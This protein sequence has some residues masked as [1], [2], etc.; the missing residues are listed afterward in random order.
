MS[1]KSIKGTLEAESINMFYQML[2]ERDQVCV[3][4]RE[5]GAASKSINIRSKKLKLKELAIF[6]RQ[7]STML[8][9]GLTVIKCLDVLYQQTT[10]KYLK[11]VI[12]Q[13]YESVQKGEALSKAMSSQ[14]GVF[15]P[16]FL[17]MIAAGEVGGT[18]DEVMARMADQYEK[19]NKLNNKITQALIY[20]IILVFLTICVVVM[21]LVFIVP[22]FMDM[23]KEYGGTI[24]APT[25]ILLAMSG[26]MTNYWYIIIGVVVVIVFAWKAFLRSETGR[27]W[28]DKVKIKLPVIGK[29]LLV[30]I[31]SRFSRTFASLYSS[32]IPIVQSLDIVGGVLNNKFVEEKV[33]EVSGN[34][35]RGT[36]LSSAV[37]KISVFPTMLCSMLSIGEESGN[38]EDILKKTAAFYDEESDTAIQKLISLIEPVMIIILAVIVCF[39]IL[40]IILPIYTI[41]NSVDASV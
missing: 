1:G 13:V 26:A 11:S 32:G 31:S 21:M 30:I 20:P 41:Y 7:F 33:Q 25:R 38:L 24:P 9:S 4:V 28:W 14:D 10:G 15:P 5:A 2:S 19:E 16:L 17:S 35:S 3:S 29:L 8:S 34:V 12:L 40:S 18:L 23:F 37:R 27:L 36:S 39:V 6:S 22:R